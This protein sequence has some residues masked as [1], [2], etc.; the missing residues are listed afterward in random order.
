[1]TAAEIIT[2]L[3]EVRMERGLALHEVGA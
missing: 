1:M 3:T 2:C